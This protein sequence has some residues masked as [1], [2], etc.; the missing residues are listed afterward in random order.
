MQLKHHGSFSVEESGLHIHQEYPFIGASPD[1]LVQTQLASTRRSYCDFVVW[2]ALTISGDAAPAN[3]AC[4]PESRSTL[5]RT[6]TSYERAGNEFCDLKNR[7]RLVADVKNTFLVARFQ[8]A[9]S[10]DVARPC[11]AE[12]RPIF[13]RTSHES[14]PYV[15]FENRATVAEYGRPS[16]ELRE[17]FR[18]PSSVPRPTCAKF[19]KSFVLR[20]S[21]VPVSGEG[22]TSL[23]RAPYAEAEEMAAGRIES[24]SMQYWGTRRSP[25]GTAS[26][27][28]VQGT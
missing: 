8:L 16:R 11:A 3:L 22:S 23:G 20:A 27:A 18:R 12:S 5:G 25:N 14:R 6:G 4:T 13:G 17:T 2:R 10:S 28:D 7:R 9:R 24:R 15:V 1:G 21:L 19:L 26:H